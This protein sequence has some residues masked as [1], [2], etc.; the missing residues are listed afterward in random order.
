MHRARAPPVT[1]AC[2][3]RHT[4]ESTQHIEGGARRGC[5]K[6]AG[7]RAEGES[8]HMC[9]VCYTHFDEGGGRHV[10]ASRGAVPMALPPPPS[11][12]IE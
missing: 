9:T 5:L 1:R 11:T 10:S 12:Q 4:I 2:A 7:V 8:G 6:E 3:Q